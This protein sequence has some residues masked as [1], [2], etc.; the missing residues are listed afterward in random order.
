M[1]TQNVF[2][3]YESNIRSYC[4]AFPA[5]IRKATGTQLWDC[6]GKRYLDFL[7][8]AGSLNY[9]H[10]N[11]ALKQALLEYI[12]SDG[13]THSLDLYT[14][15]K[16]SFLQS[17]SSHILKPRQLDYV[18]QFTGPTGTNAVEAAFKIA[19]KVTGRHGIISFTNGFHGVSAGALAATGSRYLRKAAGIPLSGVTPMP[20][21]GYFGADTD[22]ISYLQKFLNDASSGVDVPAAVI[23]EV[24]QGEGGIK[25]A[26]DDWLRKLRALCTS[27][28]IL[29]IIDDIQAG[30]GRTGSFF[31]FESAGITPDIV[32]LSKSLSGYGLPFSLTLIRRD[33][34]IWEPGEHNGTF[35]GNNHAFVTAS[36]A[37]EYYWQDNKLANGVIENGAWLARNLLTL[38]EQYPDKF[39]EVRGRGMMRGLLCSDPAD[40]QEISKLAF[41][42]GLIVELA[43]PRDEVLKLLCPLTTT[44]DELKEGMD[45]LSTSISQ[46]FSTYSAKRN[47][48]VSLPVRKA[49]SA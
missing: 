10:N 42:N 6:N 27:F 39:P 18:A 49:S 40:A 46:H 21:D 15:A 22:T 7:A 13:I 17:F 45:L 47:S 43:G 9:G 8:G 29:L 48:A 28:D 37:I 33:H 44:I 1:N 35:R 20:Y 19:R 24:V 4:R 23:V 38:A 31:S 25:T 26:S 3:N 16:E 34:D 5:V 30:C 36:H 14:E 32:T 12:E 41:D 2:T 11:P